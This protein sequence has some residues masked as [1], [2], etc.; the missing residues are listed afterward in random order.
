M[1]TST[2]HPGTVPGTIKPIF[3]FIEPSVLRTGPKM[4]KIICSHHAWNKYPNEHPNMNVVNWQRDREA[5]AAFTLMVSRTAQRP[6]S[7]KTARFD[8]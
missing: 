6:N 8:V 2:K 7:P 1:A 3:D 4:L 5:H